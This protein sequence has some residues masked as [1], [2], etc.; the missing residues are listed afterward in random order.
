MQTEQLSYVLRGSS[1]YL[2]STKFFFS[3]SF[4]QEGEQVLPWPILPHCRP[5]QVSSDNQCVG[6]RK[7]KGER[8]REKEEKE[9]I[10]IIEM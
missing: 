3:S 10:I 7:K 4:L 2:P 8:E 1:V 6:S 9:I 5:L